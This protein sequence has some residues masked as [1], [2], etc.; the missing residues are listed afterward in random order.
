M[1]NEPTIQ[2]VAEAYRVLKKY[3]EMQDVCDECILRNELYCLACKP[4]EWDKI[5]GIE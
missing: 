1:L 2:E 5:G 4:C 3:C